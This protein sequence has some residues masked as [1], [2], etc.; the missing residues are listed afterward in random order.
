MYCSSQTGYVRA[1]VCKAI[2]RYI[3][4]MT[5]LTPCVPAVGAAVASEASA[6]DVVSAPKVY[7]VNE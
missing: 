1:G 2:F 7:Q 6:A 4:M 5:D 3:S